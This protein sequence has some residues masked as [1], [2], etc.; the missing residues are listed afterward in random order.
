LSSDRRIGRSMTTL[1]SAGGVIGV[2][3]A[4]GRPASASRNLCHRWMSMPAFNASIPS[5]ATVASIEIAIP[6]ICCSLAP[7]IGT[8]MFFLCSNSVKAAV[9]GFAWLAATR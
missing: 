6:A 3:S 5:I 9:G 2:A 8:P 1:V 4:S 7:R